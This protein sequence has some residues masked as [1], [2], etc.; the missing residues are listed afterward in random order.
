[1]TEEI[2]KEVVRGHVQIRTVGYLVAD[3]GGLYSVATSWDDEQHHLSGL[4]QIPKKII[5]SFKVLRKGKK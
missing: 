4:Y 5:T 2:W 3:E 1:M